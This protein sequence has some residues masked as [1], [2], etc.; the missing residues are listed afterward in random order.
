MPPMASKPCKIAKNPIKSEFDAP[1]AWQNRE[2]EKISIW[3]HPNHG[4]IIWRHPNRG[5]IVE[6]IWRHPNR[7]KII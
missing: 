2:L 1:K 3:R 6:S 7:C 5:K 4:K